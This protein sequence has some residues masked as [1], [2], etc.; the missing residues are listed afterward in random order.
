MKPVAFFTDE[1]AIEVH[2]AT[3]ADHVNHKVT[4]GEF[5]DGSPVSLY[6]LENGELYASKRDGSFIEGP[7]A[8]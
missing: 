4:V 1:I 7:E 2:S 5:A 8:A 6:E 3:S